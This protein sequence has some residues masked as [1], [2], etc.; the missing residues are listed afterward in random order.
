MGEGVGVMVGV[1]EG[2]GVDIG[3]GVDVGVGEGIG[4][5]TT[6]PLFQINLL[7]DLTQVNFFPADIDVAPAFEHLAPAFTAAVA[8]GCSK[9]R[10]RVTVSNTPNLFRMFTLWSEL[11]EITSLKDASLLRP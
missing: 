9:T 6:T 11:L 8:I 1:G 4:F 5:L 10:A 2:E 3:E 7:P